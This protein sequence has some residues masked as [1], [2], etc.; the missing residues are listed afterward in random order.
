M[1]AAVM[2]AAAPVRPEARPRLVLAAAMVGIAL[3][4]LDVSVVN[5]ALEALRRSFS[6]RIDGLQWVLNVYTLAYAVLLLS[7]GALSD[8][9]GA[10]TVFLLGSA[11]FTLSSL[12]CGL[13]PSFGILLAA[14][15]VQGAGAA[16][17]VP[18]S[19]ALLQQAYP[20]A[21]ARARAVGLWAGVGSLSLAAGP[22]LGGALIAGIGWRG[23]FLVNLPL[24]L[25]GILLALRYAPRTPAATPRDLDLPGQ[26]VAAL[27]L[28][29][30]VGAVTQASALGW[31]DPWIVVGLIAGAILVAAFLAVEARA[32]QP[33]VPLDLFHDRSFST[34]IHVGV[35]ANFVFYGLVFVLSLFFQTVQG[36]TAFQTGLAFVPMTG[37]LL[38]VNIAAGRLIDRFGV[39]PVML[40]GLGTSFV[41]YGAMLM[42]NA[43]SGLAAFAPVF[44]LSGIGMGLTV[45]SVMTLALDGAATGRGGIAS[46]LVNAAR[47]VGGAIGVALFGSVI[48]EVSPDVFVAG[49]HVSVALAATALLSALAATY[50]F[51]PGKARSKMVS[52]EVPDPGKGRDGAW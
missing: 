15:I 28:V 44:A 8:R 3:V 35:V 13:A 51:I 12:A 9:M 23:I 7:S 6:V 50:L 18:S 43:G 1:P 32:R 26:A 42:V 25:L 31:G 19:M 16:M 36:R 20:D 41:G 30:L 22:V 45:P 2:P 5:V 37:V 17:L 27:A 34:A 46:G 10:R 4:S 38:F 39:R 49:M 11:I 40:A 52:D 47:Q 29:C 48:G 24:G 14:R 21:G 33:M